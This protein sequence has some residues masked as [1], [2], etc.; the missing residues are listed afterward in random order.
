MELLL[1]LIRGF[2]MAAADS[3]PGVSGGTVAFVLGFYDTFIRSLYYLFLGNREQKREGLIFL[4]KLGVGWVI[5][6]SSSV[7]LLGS[8]FTTHI[9]ELS[10]LFLGLSLFSLPLIYREEK[11][12]LKEKRNLIWLVPGIA[13]P[14]LLPF[15]NPVSGHGPGVDI[16]QLSLSLG[17][18]IFAA[19]IVAISAMVLPGISGSTMLLIF[20][21]YVPVISAVRDALH[22]NFAVL[23]ALAIFCLGIV[24]GITCVIRLV[25]N[26]LQD[27]RSAM[28]YFILGLL[29][30]SLFTIVNGPTTLK[31]PQPAMT[32]ATFSLVYFL[33]G[34][35][36]L[37]ILNR[38]KQLMS[39]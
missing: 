4:G 28:I 9:Y 36:L 34:G 15:L 20:G 6:M 26:A 24:T 8:L 19:A 25:K 30:G 18:Y 21:L 13:I 29:I 39:A 14:L 17:I 11:E 12:A 27:H 23:P 33:L 3:V 1:N 37:A 7:L 2:C 5:G 10:S 32:W 38:F 31:V 35:A 16:S 22:L